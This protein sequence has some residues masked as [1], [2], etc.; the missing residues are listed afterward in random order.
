[1]VVDG[2]E[3]AKSNKK[4]GDT[5]Y[6]FRTVSF[7]TN[8]VRLHQNSNAQNVVREQNDYIDSKDMTI[9]PLNNSLNFQG[10]FPLF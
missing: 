7:L 1:M 5:A 6:L 8:R 4:W 10:S 2:G 3:P 9:G